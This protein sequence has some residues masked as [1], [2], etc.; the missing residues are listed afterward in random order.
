MEQ[1][2]RSRGE[3]VKAYSQRRQFGSSRRASES[4]LFPPIR[5]ASTRQ[6]P[7]ASSPTH[8]ANVT[9]SPTSA[10]SYPLNTMT[11][12]L[13]TPAADRDGLSPLTRKPDAA[14]KLSAG[15]SS[16]TSRLSPLATSDSIRLKVERR[17]L[18]SVSDVIND[19]SKT[20]PV[21]PPEG[22]VPGP[23]P[24][25]AA[26]A[27][28]PHISRR[29]SMQSLPKQTSGEEPFSIRRK[30]EQF[31]KWHDEQY[32][33]KLKKLRME[34]ERDRRVAN[35]P[36][37]STPAAKQSSVEIIDFAK[38]LEENMKNSGK[39]SDK[40][41][42]REKTNS[43]GNFSKPT[44]KLVASTTDKQFSF[45]SHLK[46][47]KSKRCKSGGTWRTWRDV[48]DSYAYD[49]VTKYIEENELMPP[50]RVDWI[51]S[52]LKDV[53]TALDLAEATDENGNSK[54]TAEKD[55]SHV[56][57]EVFM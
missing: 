14:S 15:E 4:A 29:V 47:S 23:T 46:K 40:K 42:T 10:V 8:D 33:E 53:E 48:N 44:S 22:D 38:I 9:S 39:S 12:V 2:R 16:D 51:Q 49:N 30:I 11:S 41:Q 56:N 54:P 36:E 27:P 3:R 1:H 6:P 32:M 17:V 31:R 34:P 43:N 5:V 28:K 20:P 25:P 21:N 52:W 26:A 19:V 37:L 24:K 35:H 50:D 45:G 7:S 57:E 13:V 55:Q 18:K